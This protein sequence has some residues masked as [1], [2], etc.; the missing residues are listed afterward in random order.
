MMFSYQSP[1]RVVGSTDDK[2]RPVATA[3]G[4]SSCILG[5]RNL[6]KSLLPSS[7]IE[8]LDLSNLTLQRLEGMPQV[9][10]AL[11]LVPKLRTRTSQRRE[12][13]SRFGRYAALLPLDLIQPV[14]RHSHSPGALRLTHFL[15]SAG[16]SEHFTKRHPW[17][18]G[19]T[20]HPAQPVGGHRN[21][22]SGRFLCGAHWRRL[23]TNTVYPCERAHWR[24]SVD[25]HRGRRPTVN[26][27]QGILQECWDSGYGR[28]VLRRDFKTEMPRTISNHSI[29]C[30]LHISRFCRN[31]HFDL[32]LTALLSL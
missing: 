20:F 32:V 6:K 14:R 28:A 2:P 24:T 4:A 11:H 26:R 10:I 17:V 16:L 1:S 18:G 7:R 19:G 9:V 23:Y 29:L 31:S 5:Q 12:K 22:L 25:R 27:H 8:R 13:N 30:S 21:S 3:A 15:R